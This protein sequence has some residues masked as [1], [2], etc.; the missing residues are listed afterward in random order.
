[1]I[2]VLLIWRRETKARR[3]EIS[4]LRQL[5]L[6]RALC[7]PTARPGS[8]SGARQSPVVIDQIADRIRN[9]MQ[10]IMS[11]IN[12]HLR[13][14]SDS[15]NAD[16]STEPMENLSRDLQAAIEVMSVIHLEEQ[17]AGL[18]NLINT[19]DV[20]QR[21]SD[22]LSVIYAID[23]QI[24]INF[25]HTHRMDFGQSLSLGLLV[26][27]FF[28]CIELERPLRI[29]IEINQLTEC[30]EIRF[31]GASRHCLETLLENDAHFIQGLS[32]ELQSTLAIADDSDGATLLVRIMKE[33]EEATVD[34]RR[35]QEHQDG[36]RFN[37]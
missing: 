10:I 26:K 22:R 36:A 37:H 11:L 33:A 17:S 16:A 32:Q 23:V 25:F 20:V 31:S 28:A 7:E 24:K 3:C 15:M 2:G 34:E 18:G 35:H 9:N 14:F 1:M 12:V 6:K 19:A 4:D 29:G 27:E 21:V 5:L 13:R 8:A 30:D